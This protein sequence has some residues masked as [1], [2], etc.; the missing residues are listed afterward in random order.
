MIRLVYIDKSEDL[1]MFLPYVCAHP[2]GPIFYTLILQLQQ[3]QPKGLFF[4]SRQARV[5]KNFINDTYI[6]QATHPQ[7]LTMNF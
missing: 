5:F 6:D 7:S 3:E 1:D 2:T 4:E